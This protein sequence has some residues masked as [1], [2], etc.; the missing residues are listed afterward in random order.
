MFYYFFF[1]LIQ[2]VQN[3]VLKCVFFLLSRTSEFLKS[4][5]RRQ[6]FV[7]KFY[8]LGSRREVFCTKNWP[9]CTKREV[10]CTKNWPLC[11]KR[12]VLKFDLVV[13]R[14]RL[15]VLKIDLFVLKEVFCNKNW[16]FSSKW[17]AFSIKKWP[18]CSKWEVFVTKV[19]LNYLSIITN[20]LIHDLSKFFLIPSRGSETTFPHK[21]KDFQKNLKTRFLVLGIVI[22][23][24]YYRKNINHFPKSHSYRPW[25]LNK[26][27]FFV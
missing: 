2:L 19:R 1:V 13:L 3:M 17:E 14:E 20:D 22:N 5:L 26:G 7:L 21:K 4:L 18:L 9:F 6:V 12:V 11:S 25:K 23:F 15:S 8:Q 24:I 10:F 16:L 27:Y